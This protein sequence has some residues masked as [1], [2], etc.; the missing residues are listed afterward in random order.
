MCERITTEKI[1]KRKEI[2]KL[3]MEEDFLKPMAVAMP[4]IQEAWRISHCLNIQNTKI[5]HITFN[6]KT[7][8]MFNMLKK[9]LMSTSI[10]TKRILLKGRFKKKDCKINKSR[11][12][13]YQ[14]KSSQVKY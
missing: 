3:I 9:S 8:G 11:G 2:F 12:N 7:S 10:C 4:Q 1:D 14:Q 5:I 13:P 6:N